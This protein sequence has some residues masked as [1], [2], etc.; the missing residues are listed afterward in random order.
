MDAH[1]AASASPSPETKK[2]NCMRRCHR[3]AAPG[4]GR[5]LPWASGIS[6]SSC[7]WLGVSAVAETPW[8]VAGPEEPYPRPFPVLSSEQGLQGGDLCG[9]HGQVRT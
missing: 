2:P 4:V 8:L 1:G 3:Q 7:L 6:E 5:T 9:P